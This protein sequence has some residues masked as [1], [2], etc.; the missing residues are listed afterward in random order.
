MHEG[1]HALAGLSRKR[2]T[3]PP[4][5]MAPVGGGTW[6]SN[7]LLKGPP[8]SCHVRREGSDSRGLMACPTLW[9]GQRVAWGDHSRTHGW[10][11]S[12]HRSTISPPPTK[13]DGIKRA[14]ERVATILSFKAKLSGR[15][16]HTQQ[17]AGRAS[18][19]K[20]PRQY[21]HGSQPMAIP[22]WGG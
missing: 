11:M 2:V 14:L 5:N 10:A 7:S 13:L 16:R 9:Q 17:A 1:I 20:S 3:L 4:T 18:C 15:R 22:F 19:H 12:L 21:G 8:V 6:K